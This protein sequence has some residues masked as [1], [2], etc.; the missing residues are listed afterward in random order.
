M[1]KV[2]SVMLTI[3]FVCCIFPSAYAAQP[4]IKV[5]KINPYGEAENSVD[6][7]TCIYAKGTCYLFLPSEII[8]SKAKVYFV[9]SAR[10][11]ID[12]KEI[13]SG[14]SAKDFTPGT[15]TLYCDGLTY[16]LT[17]CH[18]A[19]IPA[20]FITTESGSLTYL[21]QNKENKEKGDIRIYENGEISLDCELKQIKGRGNSTWN[22]PKKPYNFKLDD[23]TSV[24]GMAKAKKWTLLAN[25]FDYS[26]IHNV[27]GWEFAKAFGIPYT[28][29]YRLVDLYINGNY[30]GNYA[31]CESVEVG[32]NRVDIND[33]EKDNEKA[34]PD[35]DFDEISQ[36]GTGF[37]KTVEP[38]TVKGSRKWVEIPDMPENITG[39]YLLEYEY[40]I[41]YNQEISGFVTFN[42]QP[43]VIKSPEIAGEAEVNYIAD[44]MDEANAALYSPTGVN[45]KGR[46]YSE[47]FDVSS[48]VNMY[49]FQ[50]L[51]MNFDAGLSSFYAYK[52]EDVDKIVFAPIWDLD[53]AFGSR[54]ANANV[55]LTSHQL[56]WA[57]QIG[58]HNIPTVLSAAYSHSDFRQAVRTRWAELQ[59]E[60]VFEK[61]DAT[62]QET[63]Y[64]LEPSATMNSIRWLHFST[65]D[66]LQ[67]SSSWLSA[68]QTSV[69][70][71]RARTAGLDKGFGSNGAYVY[72]DKN[73][74]ISEEWALVSPI[75]T[76][77]ETAIIR[78]V[79]GNGT[80]TPPLGKAFAGWNTAADGSGESYLPGDVITLQDEATVLYAVWEDISEENPL[81]TLLE[82]IITLV[83]KVI[84]LFKGL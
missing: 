83:E 27:Y 59:Y 78:P 57:N 39:G 67:A 76:V 32:E 17:V 73:G 60:Q 81:I 21:H 69:D 77:G 26:L 45:E 30:L 6:T 12:G 29:E 8:L 43:I 53:N 20:M 2:I 68:T 46:H 31:V 64:K 19:N 42:G 54:S 65:T 14:G 84:S 61:V 22:Y 7:V 36:G 28:S 75:L 5:L 63:I 25:Y 44:F 62:V 15:H 47:Y 49:I 37:G 23:K 34:N 40:G 55:P 66:P 50:E 1:K 18:S 74:G 52:Q 56:W 72:Y 11:T 10:V 79:T 41:R 80:I 38:Y 33:L 16:P 82:K 13:V 4:G 51:A 3:V 9:A 70:F 24:L 58:E 48:L 35:I 71:V